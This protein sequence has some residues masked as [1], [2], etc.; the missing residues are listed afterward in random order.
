M[1][2]I[3]LKPRR[4]SLGRDRKAGKGRIRVA[5]VLTAVALPASWYLMSGKGHE[6]PG[7]ASS[8]QVSMLPIPPRLSIPKEPAVLAAL[9]EAEVLPAAAE[10]PQASAAESPLD[11]VVSEPSAPM[12]V[13]GPGPDPRSGERARIVLDQL[14]AEGEP[15]DPEEV[16][17]RAQE[18]KNAGMLADAYLLYFFAA[19]QGHAMS[20]MALGTIHDP[21]YHSEFTS[22]M[23]K[24]DLTQAHKWYLQA[25]EGGDPVAQEHLDHLRARVELAAADGD[26][27]AQRL[28]LQWR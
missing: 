13:P 7:G 10:T 15:L 27:E 2:T 9:E 3:D 1:D 26:A 20:A 24:P 8:P 22:I 19:R 17:A 14:E 4:R 5:M 11:G 16:Y 6:P 23:D 21:D 25:A 18:F 28:V 12:A